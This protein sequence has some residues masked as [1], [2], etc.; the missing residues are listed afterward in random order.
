[1]AKFKQL[2]AKIRKKWHARRQLPA[3]RRGDTMIEV[4]LASAI[5]GFIALLT[6]ALMNSG[7]L[8]SQSNLQLTMA[9]NEVNAQAEA[10]R[11]IHNA[12]TNSPGSGSG[13]GTWNQYK[14]LW[15]QVTSYA[16]S[17]S[18]L[19]DHQAPDG[20][21]CQEVYDTEVVAGQ[22]IV[23]NTNAVQLGAA[24]TII[25]S[26]LEIT[27]SFPFLAFSEGNQVTGAYGIWVN[28]VT[29]DDSHPVAGGTTRGDPPYYEFFI[30]TCWD[31][32]G[33]GAPTRLDTVLRLYN[34]NYWIE[35]YR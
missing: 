10:L 2:F 14:Q 11:Y 25:T 12:Y 16:M 33:T 29:G 15:D 4:L 13:D 30:N 7:M 8:V 32:V 3:T 21:S 23:L 22:S 19:E 35:E 17:K 1:M 27:D 31:S 20:A 26:P 6:V 24:N 34:P 18:E 9:R 28:V 5:F